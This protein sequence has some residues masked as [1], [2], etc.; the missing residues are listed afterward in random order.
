V[1]L[2]GPGWCTTDRRHGATRITIPG[3]LARMPP[4][5]RKTL[6]LEAAQRRVAA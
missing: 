3:R 2:S 1:L 6:I 4:V 5:D